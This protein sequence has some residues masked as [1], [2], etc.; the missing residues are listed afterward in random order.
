[1]CLSKELWSLHRSSWARADEGYIGLE[2]GLR[3]V[4]LRVVGLRV[5]GLRVVGLRVVGLRVVGLELGL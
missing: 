2:V 5:V 1:M 4:G 3:V